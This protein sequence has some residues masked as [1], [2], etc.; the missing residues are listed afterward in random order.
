MAGYRSDSVVDSVI[1]K[2]REFDQDRNGC[3]DPDELK[4]VLQTCDAKTWTDDKVKGL[5]ESIDTNSDGSIQLEEFTAWALRSFQEPE[6]R[7]QLG[8]AKPKVTWKK[9]DIQ[10][11]KDGVPKTLVGTHPARKARILFERVAMMYGMA[12][13]ELVIYF[14]ATKRQMS[15][16]SIH[17]ECLSDLGFA[18]YCF[19]DAHIPTLVV[20]VRP[21]VDDI[22]LELAQ[23]RDVIDEALNKMWFAPVLQT[24]KRR[25]TELDEPGF[26]CKIQ[27]VRKEVPVKPAWEKDDGKTEES[28]Y[29]LVIFWVGDDF[30]NPSTLYGK[31]VFSL[32][33]EFPGFETGIP[34]RWSSKANASGWLANEESQ[35]LLAAG[36][37]KA[38]EDAEAMLKEADEKGD[39]ELAMQASRMRKSAYCGVSMM[40]LTK[41]EREMIHEAVA[42]FLMRLWSKITQTKDVRDDGNYVCDPKNDGFEIVQPRD[43]APDA[44]GGKRSANS[45][46]SIPVAEKL[47]MF[48]ALQMLDPTPADE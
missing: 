22:I 25:A 17:E 28:E 20:K 14:P 30:E 29:P 36:R 31:H 7:Q 18:E 32:S 16:G 9:F 40:P 1:D 24:C 45:I 42:P 39:N 21:R 19:P 33:G 13:S 43:I 46:L 3:I 44:D 48:R 34:Q 47:R 38:K 26:E 11:T 4:H 8:F 15:Y 2:F 5:L 37:E 27:L 41:P 6:F 23:N 10:I 12:P 35:T